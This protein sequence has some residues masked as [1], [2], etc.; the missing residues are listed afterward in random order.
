MNNEI[1]FACGYTDGTNEAIRQILN[2]KKEKF[3]RNLA[4]DI[5]SYAYLKA[6]IYY[7]NLR[8]NFKNN[9]EFLIY[10]NSDKEKLEKDKIKS[11][12]KYNNIEEMKKVR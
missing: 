4:D 8:S 2:N 6:Y 10:I 12:K 5:Y 9:Q 1:I 3:K 11:L 7:M